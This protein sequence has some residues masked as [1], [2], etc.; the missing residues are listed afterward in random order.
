MVRPAASAAIALARGFAACALRAR[1]AA[2]GGFLLKNKS[3]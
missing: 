2:F 1:M 3:Y